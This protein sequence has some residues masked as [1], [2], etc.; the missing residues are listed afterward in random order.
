MPELPE[1]E[2]V[3]NVIKPIIVGKKV[4]D[5]DVLRDKTILGSVTSFKSGI[6][7]HTCIDVTRIGKFLIFHFDNQNVIISH[8]R[9]EGKF[10]ELNKNEPYTKYARVVFKLDNGHKLCFDDMRC[11]GI[12]KLSNEKKYKS[13]KELAKLGPEPFDV[14]D[15]KAIYLANKNKKGPIKTALLDQSIIAGLGN[16]YVDEVLY[17]SNIHPHTPTNLVSLNEW[18]MI[19]DNSVKVLNAA[20]KSG[21]STI[22]SYHPGKGID[23]NFQL[24]LHAYGKEGEKCPVCGA[25]MKKTKTGGRGTTFC[26]KCQIKKGGPLLV[27]ITGK[28]GSGKSTVLNEFKERGYD[29]L[30]SDLIVMDLYNKKEVAELL[31]KKLGTNFTDKVDKSVLRELVI[32]EPNKKKALERAIHPLVKKEIFAWVKK[33][34]SAIKV[35]EVPLLYEAKMDNLFDFV[36]ALNSNKNVEL[37]QKRD[38]S[39]AKKLSEINKTNQYDSYKEKVDFIIE[40]NSSLDSLKKKAELIINKLISYL[41]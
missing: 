13:E 27:A 35:V 28:A 20:I 5:I 1:V 17:L 22:R 14:K 21:G 10:Y 19:I 41:G 2:T 16:I 33:S 31:N 34:K 39:T 7:N 6:T 26:P 32:K 38:P 8:L 9:M 23:G 18:K 25:V 12:M 15:V 3:K 24:Q 37:L 36:I 40:N 29:T 4:L 30:S 11:F